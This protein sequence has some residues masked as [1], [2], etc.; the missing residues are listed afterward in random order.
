MGLSQSDYSKLE[1]RKDV[2][3]STLR[4]AADALNGRLVL[5]IELPEGSFEIE[6]GP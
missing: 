2:R 6:I 3:V 5:L 4:A 1:R